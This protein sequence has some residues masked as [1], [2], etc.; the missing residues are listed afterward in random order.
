MTNKIFTVMGATGNTGSIVADTLLDNGYNVR[1]IG[2]SASKLSKYADRGAEIFVGDA[3][4]ADFL[5]NAFKGADGVYAMIP[6][7]YT[8][9]DPIGDYKQV[10]SALKI[11]VEN[12]GVNR[13]VVL[14]GLGADKE[15]G[16]GLIVGLHTL[17]KYLAQTNA[18]Q[19][20][21][22]AGFFFNNFFGSLPLIK[23]T[24]INGGVHSP[25]LPVYMTSTTD[26]GVLAANELMNGNF[27]GVEIREYLSE[28]PMTMS[29]ATTLIGKAIGKPDLPYLLFTEEDYVTGLANAGISSEVAHL[30][31]KMGEAFNDGKLK[32]QQQRTAKTTAKSSFESF[33]PI[34]AQVYNE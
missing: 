13:L 8:S 31:A 28:S 7:D 9:T 26:I 18:D 29:E 19:L 16:T 25:D 27:N 11:A 32:P 6:P 34:L 30:L 2:R 21:I 24:G 15:S 10:A 17:E 14:S 33:V 20:I 23:Y 4:D 1:V 3:K 12:S 5:I 22:R